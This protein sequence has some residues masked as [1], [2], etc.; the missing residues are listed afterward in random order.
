MRILQCEKVDMQKYEQVTDCDV[1]AIHVVIDNIE[2][3]AAEMI[4]TIS[5]TSWIA[6]LSAVDQVSFTARAKQTIEKLVN[7]IFSKITT[8]VT[9]EFGE[10]LVSLSAQDALE[11]SLSHK[12]VPLSELFKERKT[13]NSGFDFHTESHTSIV[14]FGEAK[15]SGST[16]PYSDA[17]VQIIDFIS[18]EKDKMELADLQKFVSDVAIESALKDKRAYIAAFS[19]NAARPAQIFSNILKSEY[20]KDLLL[21]PELY[22]I[23]VEIDDSTNS[24]SGE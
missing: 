7:E 15:Y 22:L 13:G 9:D 10:Y 18:N 20:I 5:S 19:I 4:N 24:G 2:S 3:R 21:Y 23:G 12:K 1:Y 14:A 16:N 11:S 8:S 6:K 17:L